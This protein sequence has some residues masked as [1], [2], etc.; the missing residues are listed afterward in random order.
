MTAEM[1]AMGPSRITWCPRCAGPVPAPITKW[2]NAETVSYWY[3][4]SRSC[5]WELVERV[6]DCPCEP[7][8][9][10]LHQQ[11]KRAR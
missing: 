4:G 2:E 8:V 9:E 3:C 1:T 5:G 10:R 6:P 11:K 7:C